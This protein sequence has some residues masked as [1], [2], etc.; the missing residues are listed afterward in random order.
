VGGQPEIPCKQ[1]K[2]ERVPGFGSVKP[3]SGQLTVSLAGRGNYRSFQK[4]LKKG[5]RW[6]P[7]R[8]RIVVYVDNARCH[9]AKALK[10]SS[11]VSSPVGNPLFAAVLSGLESGRAS[12]VVHA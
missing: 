2:H 8:K 3:G 7:D 9:R 6:Y 1:V 5:L 12:V 4:H 10:K 11:F